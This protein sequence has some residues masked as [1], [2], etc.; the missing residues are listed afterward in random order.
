MTKFIE[1]KVLMNKTLL[2]DKIILEI[3]CGVRK[4]LSNA[5]DRVDLED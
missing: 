3:G 1:K 4:K 5:F 2:K